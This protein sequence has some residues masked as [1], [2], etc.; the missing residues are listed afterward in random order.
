MNLMSQKMGLAQWS[1]SNEYNP[2]ARTEMRYVDLEERLRSI[3]VEAELGFDIE[4]TA[5]EVQRCLNC[6]IQ[7]DFEA[8]LC[9][10]CDACI[11]ICPLYCLTMT[12][13]GTE[14]DLRTRLTA[15]AE[16]LDQA[17][18]AS[19][20]L[21]QTK[22]IMVKDED[23][24]VHCGLCADRCPTAAWDMR[25]FELLTPHAGHVSWSEAQ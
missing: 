6:D 1:Y 10:E 19:E 3:A 15:P 23:L 21:P 22:R 5:R 14:A 18:F 7:T 17:I 24:C 11:D 13:N 8:K 20:E 12:E 9:I 16:N 2:E 4:E 25:K